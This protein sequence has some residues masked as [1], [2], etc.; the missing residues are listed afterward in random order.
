MVIRRSEIN[1]MHYTPEATLNPLWRWAELGYTLAVNARLWCYRQRILLPSRLPAPVISIGNLTTGGTG[2]TPMTISLGNYLESKGLKV[3]VLSRGY[4]RKDPTVFHEANSPQYGDEP[5][6]MHQRL[7]KSKVYVGRDRVFVGQ[8]AFELYRP[9]V[10][11]LDDGFQHMRLFRDLNIVLVDGERGFGNSHLLPAGPLREPLE[12]LKRADWVLLTKQINPEKR[13]E[14]VRLLSTVPQGERIRLGECP[15]EPIGLWH[16]DS[17]TLKSLDALRGKATYLISAIAQPKAFENLV[18]E[19]LGLELMQHFVFD[20]H[21][22]Y[23]RES[24]TTLIT[25]LS[26]QPKSVVV[27]TEKDWIKIQY[28]LPT[29]FHNR[30]YLLRFE[31]VFDW[32]P[33]VRDCLAP[34]LARYVS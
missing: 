22:D 11:I 32:E 8:E 27:T 16:P 30:I 12:Q 24:L 18:E 15:F 3:A 25:R 29:D 23:T 21:F 33:V 20:D 6:L 34:V 1:S 13:E 7:E 9:D 28:V 5:F 31:P 4:G 2:K 26:N 19:R 17:R 10:F 14:I